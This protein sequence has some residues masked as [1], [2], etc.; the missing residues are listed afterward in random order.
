MTVALKIFPR[1]ILSLLPIGPSA[2][3][4][5]GCVR[6]CAH[7]YDLMYAYLCIIIILHTYE[8]RWLSILLRVY[9]KVYIK[10]YGYSFKWPPPAMKTKL[11][12]TNITREMIFFSHLL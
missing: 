6:T 9:G 8:T 10:V 1:G 2:M 11:F 5:P 7:L 4:V 12:F 3:F